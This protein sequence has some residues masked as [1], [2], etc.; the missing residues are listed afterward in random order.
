MQLQTLTVFRCKSNSTIAKSWWRM[1]EEWSIQGVKYVCNHRDYQA[2]QKG[3]P[4]IQSKHPGVIF[5]VKSVNI[6]LQISIA[7]R[8]MYS[9][10]MRVINMTENLQP[11][12]VW[13]NTFCHYMKEWSMSA[14]N[15]IIKLIISLWCRVI[16]V[17]WKYFF[18]K[19]LTNASWAHLD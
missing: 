2:S 6:S 19:I 3:L 8:Y 5:L 1:N 4:H 18:T 15:V 10:Y 12:V 11:K 17:N 14:I 7:W 13:E 9:Q 16:L